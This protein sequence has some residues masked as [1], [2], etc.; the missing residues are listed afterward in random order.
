MRA[1]EAGGQLIPGLESPGKRLEWAFD[2]L[3]E[4]GSVRLSRRAEGGL[5]GSQE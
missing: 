1:S 3:C 4:V 2:S 5:D